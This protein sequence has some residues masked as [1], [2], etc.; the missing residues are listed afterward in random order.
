MNKILQETI[1]DSS[2][3]ITESGCWI[4]LRGSSG[5]DYGGLQYGSEWVRAH[6]AS[7]LAFK[8]EIPEGLCVLH[9]CD[10]PACVNP[11]HL[12]LGTRKD[13]AIDKV[14]KGRWTGPY[15][16]TITRTC[17]VDGCEMEHVAKGLCAKHYQYRLY[18]KKRSR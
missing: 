9:R 18:W 5:Q 14:K 13:N 2:I 12:F 16:N 4:W 3:P 8:G 15:G 17:T 11:D 1:Q 6:R 10:T 7:W